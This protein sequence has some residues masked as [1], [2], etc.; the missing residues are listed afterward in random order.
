MKWRSTAAIEKLPGP[1]TG[2]RAVR[3]EWSTDG[4]PVLYVNHL[5]QLTFSM[6]QPGDH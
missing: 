3:G 1:T 2:K 6:V 4:G 5:Q